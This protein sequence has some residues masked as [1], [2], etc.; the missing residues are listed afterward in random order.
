MRDDLRHRI[1]RQRAAAALQKGDSV[2]ED[3][4]QREAQL[5]AD[6]IAESDQIF[7]DSAVLLARARSEPRGSPL[8]RSA[9]E[10]SVIRKINP[11]ALVT[12][13]APAPADPS[14]DDAFLWCDVVGEAL[15]FEALERRKEINKAVRSLQRRIAALE[16]RLVE[17]ERG[18]IVDLPALPLRGRHV[19]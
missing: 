3:R 12:A 8:M 13:A 5:E 18:K 1:A 9:P 10:G 11:E 17:A 7:R 14:D 19:A 6:P 15:A 16:A 4:D 2:R